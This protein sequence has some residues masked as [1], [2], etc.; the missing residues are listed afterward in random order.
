[1]GSKG[2]KSQRQNQHVQRLNKKIRKFTKKGK[3]IA[4]LE[5]ELS[6]ML[7]EDRPTFKTGREVD[8]RLKKYVHNT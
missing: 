5:K 1:M 4:G 2:S 8:P 3:S 7:G 6:Y